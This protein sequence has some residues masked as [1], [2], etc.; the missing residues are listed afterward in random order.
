M[1]IFLIS[2]QKQCCDPSSEPSFRDGSD[3]GSQHMF[4]SRINKNYPKLS[5]NTPSY[6]DLERCMIL[7]EKKKTF[8]KQKPQ[9]FFFFIFLGAAARML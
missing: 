6:R 2:H 1:I 8:I 4:L 3:K 9:C 7:V 5:P